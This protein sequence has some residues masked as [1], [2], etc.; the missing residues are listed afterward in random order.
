MKSLVESAML[1]PRTFLIFALLCSEAAAIPGRDRPSSIRVVTDN[2]YPPFVFVDPEGKPQGILVDQWRLWEQKTGIRVDLRAL[3]WADAIHRMRTGE[4]DVID[5]VFRTEEREAFL[6]FL[7]PYQRIEVRIFF[8]R[9]IAG[10]T[11]AK[12]LGG[13]VVGVKAGDAD[14]DFLRH[15]GVNTL[16]AFPS[17]E[18]LVQAARDRKIAVFVADQPPA[19]YYLNKSGLRNA[20]NQSPPLY[21]GEFHRAVAKGDAASRRIVEDGFSRITPGEIQAIADKWSG[22]EGAGWHSLRWVAPVASGIAVVVLF[23]LVW[24]RTLQDRV[25]QRTAQLKASEERFQSIFH[26]VSDAVFIHDFETGAIVDVNQRMCAMYACTNAEALRLTI[27][28]L[29]SGVAPY[30]QATSVVWLAKA[31]AGQPQTFPWHCCRRDGSLFWGEVSMRRARIGPVDRIVVTVRD[32][33]ERQQDKEARRSGENQMR[34]VL[35]AANC[36]LWQARV[37]RLDSGEYDWK[38]YLPASSLYR[39]LFG[40]DPGDRAVLDWT[41]LKVKEADAMRA[42]YLAAL[43]SG[44]A[45]YEQEFH[46]VV[47]NAT[48]W[49]REQVSIGPVRSGEWILVGVI[50]DITERKAIEATLRESESRLAGI[51]DSAMDAIVTADETG[52]IV[53]FNHTAEAVFSCTAPEAIGRSVERF[54]PETSLSALRRHLQDRSQDGVRGETIR[55]ING[56]AVRAGGEEFPFEASV[57]STEVDGHRLFTVILRDVTERA[58]AD[59]ARRC[60]EEQMLLAQRLESVGRLAGGIA[61]DLNNILTPVLLG[62]PLLREA[63]TSAEANET[64]TAMEISARRGADII[65]QLLAFSRGGGGARAP[66]QLSLILRDMS[67]IIRETFPKNITTR[68]E[69]PPN[70]WTVNGNATQL[71]QVL[72]NL[73]VNARDAMPSG[74]TLS[75]VLENVELDEEFATRTPGITCGPHVLLSVSD[76]GEGI[77]PDVIGKIFDPFFTTKDVGRGTGLG[78]ST[79]LGIANSHGGVVQVTSRIGEGAQF[80]VYLPAVPGNAVQAETRTT[81]LPAGHGEWILVVDDEAAVRGITRKIL[82]KYNYR[83]MEAAEGREALASY[84]RNHEKI[85]VVITDLLMPVL[86]GPALIRELRRLDP[87]LPVIA[88]SGYAEGVAFAPGE[89]GQS[90]LFLAKPYVAAELLICLREALN[91]RPMAANTRSA[92]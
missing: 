28:D 60:L 70:V 59:E 40:C 89:N 19:L 20:F 4:S 54:I 37:V 87:N 72:M 46:A 31:A 45:G 49:L 2:N 32:I 5:T 53:V 25:R 14:A 41:A 64:L 68:T 29:S 50:T 35:E 69:L 39:R 65:G 84:A 9:E 26:S 79:V 91:R 71:H 57:S 58:R 6:D 51:V 62:T 34:H 21:V 80:R 3:D 82:E 22:T 76:T 90:Q 30:D 1:A 16:L 81:G 13:F 15:C 42:H 10:I 86:D 73:C 24:N 36:L 44:A 43:A 78:L 63:I 77:P 66:V 17:Y 52:R 92:V 56:S 8:N 88:A 33:T 11:D 12:S 85:A 67:A 7:A 38:L 83:V 18:S 75:I 47:N 27:G 55:T 48:I 74:G 23:L 61:H